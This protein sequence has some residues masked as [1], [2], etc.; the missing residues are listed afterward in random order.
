ML[1]QRADAMRR[2]TTSLPALAARRTKAFPASDPKTLRIRKE[3]GAKP[4]N[5]A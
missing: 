1:G 3:H 2:L 4:T 5:I